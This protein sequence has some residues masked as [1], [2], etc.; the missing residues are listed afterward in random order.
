M[1]RKTAIITGAAGSLGA[2]LSSELVRAGWSVVLLDKNLR[3][4]EKAYDRIGEG[5]PGIAV[6][7][8]LD[9]VEATPDSLDELLE[10]VNSE[11]GGIDAVVHGA[12]E[13]KSLT[14]VEHIQPQDWLRSIQVNLNAAWLLSAMALPYLRES[15]SGRLIY[16]LE[17]LEKVEGPF[18]GAYGVAKHALRALTRQLA[19]ECAD[20]PVE[21][22]GV[23]PG[24]MGS[25]IRTRAYHSENP[26]E[27]P[28][29][30]EPAGRIAAYL[31]G[32][33]KWDRVLVDFTAD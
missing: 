3:G 23:N 24:P 33:E 4:L 17:D 18:W 5:G 15:G 19:A 30:G 28:G 29:A 21:V 27:M 32:K 12:A 11:F 8:Q 13:F 25:A 26:A 31:C 16:L 10:S 6:L 14:P 1:K 2:E 22:R 9:L 20:G 7:H